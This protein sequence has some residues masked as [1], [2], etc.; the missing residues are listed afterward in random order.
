MFNVFN[1]AF[2]GFLASD[3][4]FRDEVSLRLSGMSKSAYSATS[5]LIIEHSSLSIEH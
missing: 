3:R 4:R 5:A 1:V 2:G